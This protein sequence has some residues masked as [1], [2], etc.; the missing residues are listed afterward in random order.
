MYMKNFTAIL[1]VAVCA[2]TARPMDADSAEYVT[3]LH[4]VEVVGLKQMPDDNLQLST[5]VEGKAIDEY[6]VLTVRDMSEITPN[7]YVPAY[8]SRMTSSIYVRGLGAR[9]DQPVVG[10]NVDNVPYL[11]KD[12]YDFDL[13]DIKRVEVLRGTRAVLNGRNSMAGQVNIYTLSPWDFQGFRLKAE[14]GR[15]NSANAAASWYGRLSGNLATSVMGNIAITDGFYK[16]TA[17]PGD[18]DCGREHQGT[19]RWKLSWHPASR[20]SLSNVANVSG[21][22][23]NGYPYEHLATGKIAYN[24]TT[25]YRRF[26]FSDGLTISY[27]GKRMIATSVT[28]VQY[29]DDNMTLDQ[30]FR[31][32]SIF[33]LTQKRHEWALTQDIF[34]KGVRDRYEWL[35]GV[36]GFYKPTDMK[37]PVTFGDD[38]IRTLIENN[39]NSA[40]PPGMRLRWDERSI[41]LGSDFKT[42]DGGFAL[43]HQSSYRL[44]AFTFQGGLRWDIEH[45]GM[46]Y[47]SHTST[48]A[49]MERQTPAG[50]IPLGTRPIEIDDH[51]HLSQTF[52]ELLP[53]VIVSYRAGIVDISASAA[54]G[55]KAG[56]YN[57]QMFSDV[58]LQQMM[59]SM[60]QETDYDIDKMLTYKP[61]RLWNYEL[62]AQIT[63][64]YGNFTAEAVLFLMNCRNQQLTVFPDGNTTGRAMTNAGRTRSYGVE[65]TVQW[66]PVNRLSLRGSYGYTHAVFTRYD[67][68][69]QNLKGKRLPYAPAHTLFAGADYTLPFTFWGVTPSVSADVRAVGDI[70]WDDMNSA[71]QPFYAL[72]NTSVNFTHRLCSVSLWG[73]NITNT[74]YNT[75]YFTSVGN[76]FVQRA[77]PWSVGATL[78]INFEQ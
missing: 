45:V 53:Q 67:N 32:E 70:Y 33:T 69:R 10:L 75:F 65:T 51:G 71:R 23:Q 9:I 44:G 78:R 72:L 56:G 59:A 12:S 34:A 54:K 55:Y 77:N 73:T 28:S 46:D 8:G 15:A 39:V 66:S 14:F 19:F 76:V 61:E 68:G 24:D 43:Y 13:V 62:S 74:K 30:D 64:T 1:L 57:T 37:A 18:R 7:F 31:P 21:Y 2:V 49:T 47:D 11:N 40:L 60:G 35:I 27:T 22:K 38:G 42:R 26:G 4:D 29:I 20:W 52:N 5:V 3:E 63:P 17:N 58:L 25:F 36:F 16:N 6:R 41:L 50:W 48:S